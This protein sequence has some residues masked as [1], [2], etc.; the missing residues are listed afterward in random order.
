[1]SATPGLFAGSRGERRVL[2]VVLE[3]AHVRLGQ[4]RPS[5]RILGVRRDDGREQADRLVDIRLL[6]ESI[7]QRARL[8]QRR[9]RPIA[10][11]ERDRRDRARRSRDRSGDP[12]PSPTAALRLTREA[13]P[14]RA[15]ARQHAG[16][17]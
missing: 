6:V 9:P 15:R 16:R 8:R 11:D 1:M 7:E 4:H 5:R 17:P 3:L 10:Q 14:G 12:A 13:G 2:Q